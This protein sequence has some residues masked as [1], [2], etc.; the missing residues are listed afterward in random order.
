ME[1]AV[2]CEYL[3][4]SEILLTELRVQMERVRAQ[5]KGHKEDM[6]QRRYVT[7]KICHKEDMS[8]RTRRARHGHVH[9]SVHNMSEPRGSKRRRLHPKKPGSSFVSIGRV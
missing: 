1:D 3:S 9:D 7:K 4:L 2:I 8:Q 5:K 6:S